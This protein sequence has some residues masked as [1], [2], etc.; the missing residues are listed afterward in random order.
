MKISPCTDLSTFLPGAAD[1]GNLPINWTVLLPI[2]GLRSTLFLLARGVCGT[3]LALPFLNSFMRKNLVFSLLMAVLLMATALLMPALSFA[4][5]VVLDVM[6][7]DEVSFTSSSTEALQQIYAQYAPGVEYRKVIVSMPEPAMGP[8][9]IGI[10]SFLEKRLREQLKEKLATALQPDDEIAYLLLETHGGT[11]LDHF[12]T[13]EL[14]G[15]FSAE[16]PNEKFRE[17][18]DPLRSRMARNAAIIMNACSVFE[19]GE[20]Q[21]SLRA[22]ALLNYFGAVDGVVYGSKFAEIDT[23]QTQGKYFSWKNPVVISKVRRAVKYNAG[24]S[25][26]VAVIAAIVGAHPLTAALIAGV[27]MSALTAVVQRSWIRKGDRNVDDD[28][29]LNKGYLLQFKDGQMRSMELIHKMRDLAKSF[30]IKR[31]CSMIY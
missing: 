29:R 1:L 19:D 23:L 7:A 15:A 11:S 20:E 12:S 5:S 9:S 28:P 4:K 27:G 31:S 6:L 3:P 18:F 21:A 25:M 24:L 16:G 22:Q 10:P 26:A 14:M 13:L 8:S 2:L 30:G 17:L